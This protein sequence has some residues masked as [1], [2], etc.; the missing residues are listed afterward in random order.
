M[1]LRLLAIA[2]VL[3]AAIQAQSFNEANRGRALELLES[4]RQSVVNQVSGLTDDQ[5]TYKRA[6]D[7]WSVFECVEHLA[8]TEELLL[9]A[10]QKPR[11]ASSGKPR[12]R[13]LVEG[14]DQRILD[15]T[16]DRSEKFK[17][18]EPLVPKAQWTSP[19]DALQA[20]LDRRKRSL[21]FAKTTQLDLRSYTYTHPYF[22]EIDA[23]Q[24]LLL[25]SAHSLRHVEQI[26]EI[27][28]NQKEGGRK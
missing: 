13:A 17:A 25:L 16:P 20:F 8:L 6:P 15:V 27:R 18:P 23:Y 22:G 11:P 14:L 21:D 4:S 28:N 5:W 2:A 19:H 1:K 9:S 12:D 24:M 10:A 7:V 26:K 3:C